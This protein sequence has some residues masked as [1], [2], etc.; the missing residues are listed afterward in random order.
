MRK[1]ESALSFGDDRTQ[2]TH[3]LKK[4][5]LLAKVGD[6]RAIVV[7]EHL[8]AED[9]VGDLGGVDEVHLEE[10]GLEVSLLGTVLLESVEE[11]R[12]GLLDHVLRHE[13]ID[14]LWNERGQRGERTGRDNRAP[15]HPLDVHQRSTLVVDKLTGKLGSLIGVEASDVLEKRGVVGSVVDALGV[16]DNLG[17]LSSL[18]EAGAVGRG[19]SLATYRSG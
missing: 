2:T 13:D 4:T 6:T 11:E 5:S 17:K 1:E 8:V 18:G 14:N 7:R 3:A 19:S 15:T 9:G 12:G 16:D 10:A